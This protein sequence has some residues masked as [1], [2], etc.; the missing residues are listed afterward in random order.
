MNDESGDLIADLASHGDSVTVARGG[1]GGHGNAHFKGATHQAPTFAE[2]G[3]PGERF[4]IRLV[5]KLLADVGIIGMPNAGKSTLISRI[6]SAR[7]KIANYPFT[8]LVPNLGAVRLDHETS[9]IVADVPGLIE[10]AHAGAGLGHAF[11]RHIERTL[12]LV[13]VLDMAA[14]ENRDP[15]H[16]FDVIN[17]ELRLFDES[18][19]AKSQIVVANKMDLPQATENLARCQDELERRGYEVFPVSAV[20]GEGVQALLWRIASLVREELQNRPEPIPG[21]H[22]RRVVLSENIDVVC[23]GDHMW[24]LTGKPIERL[25]AMTDLSNEEAAA[26]L[27]RRMERM[28]V[29]R[30]LKKKG[31]QSGDLVKVNKDSFTFEE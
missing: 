31:V 29:I 21:Q 27:H 5:L 24:R 16:D 6:S 4:K 22:L 9:F 7:P 20:T 11:L 28:G 17:Q 15:V 2:K 30:L 13:H 8:T 25:V 19:S 12:V 3:E 1:R 14:V 18:L 23:E 26:H 10:G